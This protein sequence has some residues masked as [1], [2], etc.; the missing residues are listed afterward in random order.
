MIII[1]RINNVPICINDFTGPTVVISNTPP[2]IA[3]D[4]NSLAEKYLTKREAEIIG[5]LP[6]S[7]QVRLDKFWSRI[8]LKEKFAALY[9]IPDEDLKQI[10]IVN[11]KEANSMGLPLIYYRGEPFPVHLSISH[12]EG[13]VGV[14]LNPKPCGIDIVKAFTMEEHMETS[15]LSYALSPD[16]RLQIS[17]RESQAGL[18]LMTLIWGIKEAV[19]K[20][21]GCGLVYGPATIQVIFNEKDDSADLTIHPKIVVKNG[22]GSLKIFYCWY[23]QKSYCDVYVG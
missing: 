10:E 20:Y 4:F 13:R 21:L 11:S 6:A 3:V 14:A 16:E 23:K 17:A 7:S 15:F 22:S 18:E 12:C 8:L 2:D 19:S 9:N 1:L 5:R